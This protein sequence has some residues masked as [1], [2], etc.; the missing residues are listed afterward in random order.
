MS[1]ALEVSR[2]EPS[3]KQANALCASHLHKHELRQFGPRNVEIM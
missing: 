2:F 3:Y 1:W